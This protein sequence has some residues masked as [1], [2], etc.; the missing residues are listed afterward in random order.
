MVVI[1]MLFPNYFSYYFL[2]I[3]F[4]K[5]II[6][7]RN[8]RMIPSIYCYYITNRYQVLAGIVEQR[9]LEP[10][11]HKHKLALSAIC[12]AVRTG[13]TYLGSLMWDLQSINQSI[14]S[15]TFCVFIFIFI[16]TFFIFW[17]RWVDYARLVGIQKI[18]D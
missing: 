2:P 11:L 10:I 3:F 13:N 18:R 12:F 1:N 14:K 15:S 17:C 8:S 5:L 9:F 6:I 7:M 16:H 4:L